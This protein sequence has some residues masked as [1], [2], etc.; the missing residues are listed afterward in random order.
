L[1]IEETDRMV[2]ARKKFNTD[3]LKHNVVVFDGG[4]EGIPN[5]IENG[6]RWACTRIQS[7]GLEVCHPPNTQ[8]GIAYERRQGEPVF[9]MLP[10]EESL[11]INSDG[12]SLCAAMV[13]IMK[14]QGNLKR[15]KSK[16]VFSDGKYCCVGS[17]PRRNAPGV[18]PGA[19]KMANGVICE[20]WDELIQSIKRGEH[21]FNAYVG[22]DGI[23]RIGEARKVVSWE[24]PSTSS[25]KSGNVF[26]AVAFGMNVHLRAHVDHDF[27]YSVIQAH[28]NGMVYGLNDPVVCY[29]CFPAHGIAV[30]L[31]PG[32]FLL[33]NALVYHCVSSRC[34]REDDVF[35]LSCYLKTAVVGGN[36]NKRE[37][38]EKEIECLGRYDQIIHRNKKQKR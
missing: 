20:N 17:K 26:N 30:P 7:G 32:D 9:M 37:L 13:G 16:M 1:Y 34:R 33:I 18:E 12:S 27:T 28:V 31:R 23:R 6:T 21:A 22:T 38:T 3:Y 19:Y 15:G 35:V 4:D 8:T 24:T 36:D 10:R 14:A 29:F 5:L 25:G 2:A 11:R